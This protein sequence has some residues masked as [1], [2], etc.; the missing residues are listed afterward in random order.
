M[1][2]I[3]F[4]NK[5]LDIDILSVLKLTRESMHGFASSRSFHA[6]SYRISGGADF[7]FSDRHLQAKGGELIYI[8]AYEDYRVDSGSEEL[9]VIHFTLKTSEK[10]SPEVFSPADTK[11]YELKFSEIYAEWSKKESGYIYECKAGLYKILSHSLRQASELNASLKGRLS[12]ETINYIHENYTDKSMTVASL[13]DMSNMSETY[14]RKLFIEKFSV[15]PKKYINQLRISHAIELLSSGYYTVS[16]AAFH[17]GFDS[18]NYFSYA[19]KK[20]TGLSP[21]S[22]KLK[23]L[24]RE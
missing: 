7:V 8:P 14:F 20:E 21:Q 18:Q 23:T 16:E 3:F 17:S 24:H 10:L 12:D 5:N 6:L 15:P 9:Y 13:A 11:Y 19:L 2:Y 4:D 1:I 22:Y